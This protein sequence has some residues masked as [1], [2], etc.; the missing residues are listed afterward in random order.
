[1]KHDVNLLPSLRALAVPFNL[2]QLSI[3]AA[4]SLGMAA[5]LVLLGWQTQQQQQHNW[6]QLQQDVHQLQQLQQRLLSQQ[7]QYRSHPGHP[8]QA[9]DFA[10]ATQLLTHSLLAHP[11]G[12]RISQIDTGQHFQQWH[13]QGQVERSEQLWQWQQQLSAHQPRLHWLVADLQRQ[14]DS[15]HFQLQA[16]MKP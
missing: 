16:E 14:G 15:L 1:M 6:Q 2:T 3:L 5:F 8:S 9:D 4:A 7:G 10:A 12:V 13:W 11:S